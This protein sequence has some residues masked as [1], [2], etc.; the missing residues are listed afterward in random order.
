MLRRSLMRTGILRLRQ[1]SCA[2]FGRGLDAAY[3]DCERDTLAKRASG[4]LG[5]ACTRFRRDRVRCFYGTGGESWRDESYS[6][7]GDFKGLP[8]VEAITVAH[9]SL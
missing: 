1:K 7:H 2:T 6:G 5:L 4:R 8:L 9:D 3:D